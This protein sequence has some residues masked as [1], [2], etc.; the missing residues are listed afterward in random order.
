METGGSWQRYQERK[1]PQDQRKFQ[2]ETLKPQLFS[3]ANPSLGHFEFSLPYVSIYIYFF[4][5]V[6]FD[7]A[8]TFKKNISLDQ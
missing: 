6:L 3:I 7:V 2:D 5:D 1:K 8:V 4:W